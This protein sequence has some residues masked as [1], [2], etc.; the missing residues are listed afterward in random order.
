VRPGR[1]ARDGKDFSLQKETAGKPTLLIFYRGGWCPFCTRHLAELQKSQQE[2]IDLGYQILAISADAPEDLVPTGEKYKLGYTLLSDVAMKASDAFGLAFY[3]DA[4]TSQQYA[5]RFK[6]SARHEG[7]YWL[8]V[9]AVYIVGKDGRIAFVHT[10]PNYR[11][12]LP[13]ADLL[14]AAKEINGQDAAKGGAPKQP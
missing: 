1:A 8:P 5:S 14:K 12:R 13:V 3:L 10:D 11:R 4:A 9:P 6:M 2:L 7:R